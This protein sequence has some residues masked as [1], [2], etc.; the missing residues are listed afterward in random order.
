MGEHCV[1]VLLRLWRILA[2]SCSSL[3]CLGR[4][5]CLNLFINDLEVKILQVHPWVMFYQIP[6]Q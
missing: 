5:V 3:S 2:S 4:L 6:S 1:S